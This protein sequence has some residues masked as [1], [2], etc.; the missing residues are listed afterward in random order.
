MVSHLF[1]TVEESDRNWRG[2]EWKY[3]DC[4]KDEPAE[5][6]SDYGGGFHWRGKACR[7]CRAITDEGA[8]FNCGDDA[9]VLTASYARGRPL[10]WVLAVAAKLE[11]EK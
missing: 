7:S 5:L 3:C 10:W 1:G 6:A 4:G 8:P 9:S 2:G 11:G